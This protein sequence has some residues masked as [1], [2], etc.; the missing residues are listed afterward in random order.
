MNQEEYQRLKKQKM[1]HANI[2]TET[3]EIVSLTVPYK[4]MKSN[5]GGGWMAMYQEAM[6]WMADAKLSY[7]EYRVLMKLF[8]KLDFEN[9]IRVTQTKI[10]EDLGM[11]QGNVARAIKGLLEQDIIRKGPKVGNSNTYRLNPMIG[12]KGQAIN[13]TKKEYEHL[14]RIK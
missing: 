9:Y 2:D 11:K 7:E 1:L 12:H 14:K 8:A 6:D 4:P 13:K 5:L 10:A 3:G